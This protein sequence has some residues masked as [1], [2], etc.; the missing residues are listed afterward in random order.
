[1][2]HPGPRFAPGDLFE[3]R[4]E[5]LAALGEGGFGT[6]HK[7]RQLTTGQAVALK[8]MRPPERGGAGQIERRTARF[9][10]EA[11]LCAQLHHP[12]IVRLVDAGRAADGSLYTVFAFAP[13]DN[14]A[15]LLAREG[16]LAPREA[17][18]LMLQV[19][20]ALA[21]AHAGGVIHRDLKPSNIV[22]IPTGARRNA[23]VLDFGVGVMLEGG[24]VEGAQRLTGSDDALGTPGYGAPE[25]LRGVDPSP[26]A[27]LFSWGLVFLECLTGGPVYGGTAAEIFYQLLGPDPVPLP[28]A[29]ERHS[30]GAIVRRALHKEVAAREASARAL[31]DA[32]DACD[33]R[34]LELNASSGGAVAP[35]DAPLLLSTGASAT[36]PEGRAEP[37]SGPLAGE[38]RQLTALCCR[39][40]ALA[41]A[42]GGA[43]AAVEE[44][45]E[46]LRAAL[47]ICADVSVRHRGRVVAALGDELLVYFGYPRAEEDDARRA[48]RAALAIADAVRAEGA[49]VAGR[50]VRLEVGVGVHTGLVVADELQGVRGAGVVVGAT[51][52]LAARLASLAGAGA[53]AVSAES[54]Q[55]LRATFECEAEGAHAVE[56][57]P[58]KVEVFSLRRARTG[59]TPGPT[60]DGAKAP[61]VGRDAEVGLL[62]ERW[63][64]A[65]TG[66]GQSNLVTGEPGIGKSRLARELRARI[67]NDAHAFV[68]GRCSPDTQHNALFPIVEALGSGLG[69]DRGAAG[70]GKNVARLEAELSGYGFELADA[71]PLFLPLF[72]LPVGAPYAPP[73]VSSQRQKELTLRAISSLLFA[74]AERQPVF[75]LVEDLHWADP[76]TIELL[77]RLVR[78]APSSSF[79]LLLTAR[80][81]FSPPFA[82]TAMLQ[83]HLGRLE[84]PQIE[85]MVAELSG[86]KA[87]PEAVLERVVSR[88]DG[89]PLFIEELTRATLESGALVAR[90]D[91]YE[92]TGPPSDLEIPTTLRALVTARLDRLDRAK[93]TVQFAAALGREF[94]VE[95]LSAL[96]PLGPAAVQEDLDR[97]AEAGL[98]LRRRRLKD[99]IASFKH[100]LVRDAAYESLSKGARQKVHARV[101]ATLEGRFAETARSRPDLLAHHH[102]AAGQTR[103]AAGY[104]LRA[105][106]HAL[107]R[108]AYAEAVAHASHA[109]DWATAIDGAE[110][111]EAELA[112]NGVLTQAMMS[113]RGWA[114][115][116]VKA[117]VD[118]AAVLLRRID[119]TSADRVPTLWSL[120]T[121]HHVASNRREAAEAAEALVAA[122]ER[123]GDQSLRAAAATLRG[124]AFHSDGEHAAARGALEPAVALYDPARHRDHGARFGLDSFVMATAILAHLRWFSGD[125]DDA[126]G[127]VA[128][129][130]DW[131]REVG[132]V[133]SLALGLLYGCQVFQ[134]ADDKATVAAM[135]GELLALAAKYGL[136]AYEGYA[137]VVHGWATGED[138]STEA[139]LQGLAQMGCQLGLSYFGSL[140]ADA[141]AARGD[142]DAAVA[143]LDRCLALCRENDEHHY[144]P[145]LHRRK[146]MYLLRQGPADV[147]PARAALEQ[148]ARLARRRHMPRVEALAT[149][150][151]L[152]RFGDEGQ[153]RPRLDELLASHPGLR[154]IEPPTIGRE[155]PH[156]HEQPPRLSH[157]LPARHRAGVGRPRILGR[158]DAPRRRRES[159][160]RLLRLLLALERPHA[161]LPQQRRRVEPR[162]DG[163]LVR[164]LARRHL[165]ARPAQPRARQG[166][167][168][169]AVYA[170]DR[171]VLPATP[172]LSRPERPERLARRGRPARPAAPAPAASVR[173]RP[174]L[175][176]FLLATGRRHLPRP[177]PRLAQRDLPQRAL[178]QRGAGARG[179]ARLQLAVELQDSLRR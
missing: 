138:A 92:L 13:G 130:L 71:M 142:L 154:T 5:I 62:A 121:Y 95:V 11:R 102:A 116:Q 7:A 112:A 171:G 44:L 46:L 140:P 53:V 83:L 158:A 61:L 52:R 25:Q 123:S 153:H 21:C 10:R 66:A 125:D 107:E 156:E 103:Q 128:K 58:S 109:V 65:R 14:L 175:L 67:A 36:S 34:E 115:P 81:E 170:G 86:R 137:V 77:G 105:A 63:R 91:R 16:A 88:A 55:L 168:T 41:T 143:R 60:P 150:E 133:P 19:L 42:S 165:C 43:G 101:A 96:S 27:D 176:G 74:M 26:G 82:T 139:I 114:D 32:L 152:R 117:A 50:G 72:S 93:E 132:H 177:R 20:D 30:L 23:L 167:S 39:L 64:L 84:R 1:M 100:A 4:Y 97:L 135:T 79:Y 174:R 12:N 17:R 54:Q 87:L 127:L 3:G 15:E 49:R 73:D 9:L 94:S 173:P 155:P 159:P 48:A 29:L 51:P 179:V 68:E 172:H 118:R 163:R 85:A 47:A 70:P 157:D 8:L 2:L 35:S 131:A 78:E 90:G 106:R 18:H 129:A 37:G 149:L 124:L 89:V 162:R 76:T 31:F 104:A 6:V 161:H 108:S 57:L 56:G 24:Q 75:L 141:D 146:A 45:D 160:Q 119:P 111:V 28:A 69:L 126:F 122:A 147:G 134:F 178:R 166:P 120:F 151:L 144:E 113:L 99:P 59:P 98:L 136:P 169:R 22:V 80:P 145:E 110:G 33:L 164:R 40:S 38:R 148:A